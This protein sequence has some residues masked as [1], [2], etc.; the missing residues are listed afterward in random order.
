M[1]VCSY[2][3]VFIFDFHFNIFE[4]KIYE[5]ASLFNDYKNVVLKT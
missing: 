1:S 3:I 4:G 2:I 5:V